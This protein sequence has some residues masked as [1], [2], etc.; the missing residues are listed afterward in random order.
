MNA[1]YNLLSYYFSGVSADLRTV[2]SFVSWISVLDFWR[3]SVSF[4]L[5]QQLEGF[6]IN[7]APS[8]LIPGNLNNGTVGIGVLAP[9]ITAAVTASSSASPANDSYV[10]TNLLAMLANVNLVLN[11]PPGVPGYPAFTD[12]IT[13]NATSTF[14]DFATF[15][16]FHLP[17]IYPY[18]TVGAQTAFGPITGAD[19]VVPVSYNLSLPSGL[20]GVQ[21]AA[22]VSPTYPNASLN[23]LNITGGAL[24][25]DICAR[26]LAP[27]AR[28]ASDPAAP[29]QS[30]RS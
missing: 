10:L 7:C 22:T 20:G 9:G 11:P 5:F 28:P 30:T 15:W 26:P 17:D 13:N 3:Y 25:N 2:P 4:I 16:D 23:W 14:A 21:Y 12:I 24:V 1:L 19:A 29:P 6:Q 18:L 27:G 8:E